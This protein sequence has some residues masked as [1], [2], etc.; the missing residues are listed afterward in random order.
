M[1]QR[2]T[3]IM[4][5]RYWIPI[6]VIL[7]LV[8]IRIALPFWVEGQVNKALEDIPGYTGSISDVDLHLYRGAYTIDSLVID[9]V[10]AENE[11][12]FLSVDRIDFSIEWGALIKGAIVGEVWL[13]AP[14]ISFVASE[15]EF[16]QDVDWTKTLK[17]LIPIQI[18]RFVIRQG[19]IRYLDFSTSPQIDIPLENL[20]LDILNI[21]NVERVGRDLPT[22]IFLNAVSIGGGSLNVEARANLLKQ[23]PDVD[24]T[25][26]FEEVN[27]PA[28]ND[29]LEAYVGV[30]AEQ[31][32]FNLYSEVI[33]DEG[34][35]EGYVKP[36]IRNLKI[37]NLEEG[38]VLEV[39]WEGIV[40]LVTEVFENQSKDQFASQV[41]LQGDLNDLDTG[42]YPAIWNIFRNAF[43]EAFSKQ[44]EGEINFGKDEE[45]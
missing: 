9:K 18:N 26:E 24:L 4:K 45:E 10:E 3:R 11:V 33:V 2:R 15:E 22:N 41:P 40:G 31:G 30:D 19:I 43:V 16:G 20:D 36:I 5:K 35:I 27:L 13:L 8:G 37:I 7:I 21:S 34:K 25:F 44:T 39:A 28:L 12:P 6:L 23:I 38:N 29:F 32:E 42:T 1:N 14:E 17:E